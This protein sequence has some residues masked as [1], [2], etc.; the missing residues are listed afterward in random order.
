MGFLENLQERKKELE[1]KL[2]VHRAN[3]DYKEFRATQERTKKLQEQANRL[4]AQNLRRQR[5]S[6]AR[7]KETALK[8]QIHDAQAEKHKER[9]EKIQAFKKGLST[10]L[11][12]SDVKPKRKTAKRKSAK[13]KNAPKKRRK[14]RKSSSSDYFSF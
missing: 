11:N 13:R 3:Q 5:L 7:A 6:L 9:D 10:L 1:R 12:A 14:R 4:Q 8:K 2:E